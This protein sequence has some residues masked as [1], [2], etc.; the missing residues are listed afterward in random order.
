MVSTRV[1]LL[2]LALICLAQALAHAGSRNGFLVSSR[3]L[4]NSANEALPAEGYVSW[5]GAVPVL[6]DADG[7]FT[8]VA[9]FLG[10]RGASDTGILDR[11]A[12]Y[13]YLASLAVPWT[14]LISLLGPGSSL[15]HDAGPYPAF[16]LLNTLAWWAA[17]A[18]AYWFV[19]R[20]WNDRAL[21]LATSFLVATGNGFLFMVGV[22][23]SYLL[24][25]ACVML[26]LA[27][28]EWVGAFRQP[29]Q[30]GPWLV[31]G[32]GAGVA[33]T[34]YF[35]HFVMLIFWWLYGLRRVPWRYL[36]ATSALALGI[37]FS[38]EVYGR[39]AA[40]M[41]FLADNTN[42]LTGSL[43]TW[44]A[45]LL[46]PWPAPLT[47]IRAAT[48]RGTLL[49]AFPYPW[50]ILAVTGFV[51]SSRADREWALALAM[52]GLV[53]AIVLLSLLPLPR[54]AY[55]MYPAMCVLAARGALHFGHMA[56]AFVSRMGFVP[57]H[58]R[59]TGMATAAL[60]LGALAL[61]SNLDLLGYQQ[62]NAHFHFAVSGW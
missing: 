29:S 5:A 42:V 19:Q 13:A 39:L 57:S 16:L 55:Y 48:I 27:L 8:V 46:E 33:S 9:L 60:A 4:Y 38:W 14:R 44:P 54:V 2:A 31:L 18:A 56:V 6:H 61:T 17:A 21:A 3:P 23:M 12:A 50:W 52:A 59:R 20:R 51:T 45:R 32:W 37:S 25:Y 40:G 53:P 30:L 34:I 7:V 47:Y 62:L 10:E 11:R 43:T 24:A 58:A 15:G 22:P 35:S 28:G 1:W 36:L 41:A 49:G 26:L